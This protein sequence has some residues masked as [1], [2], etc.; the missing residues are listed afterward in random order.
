MSLLQGPR[1]QRFVVSPRYTARE[2]S[3]KLYLL[4]ESAVLRMLAEWHMTTVDRL[5][6]AIPVKVHVFKCRLLFVCTYALAY[7]LNRHKK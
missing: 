3:Y 6:N 4:Q 2:N 1:Q 7:V 5:R